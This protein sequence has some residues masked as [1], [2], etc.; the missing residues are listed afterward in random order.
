[1]EKVDSESGGKSPPGQQAGAR[2]EKPVSTLCQTS[3]HPELK[4]YST[5][6]DAGAH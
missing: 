6:S 4:I 2:N 5:P 3:H 1:M